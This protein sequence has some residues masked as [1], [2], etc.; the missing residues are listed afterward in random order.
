M[1]IKDIARLAGVSVSTV[2]KILNNKADSIAEDTKRKVLQIA[3]EYHYTPYSGVKNI[4]GSNRFLLSV[5]CDLQQVSPG[6]L[7][8]VEQEADACGYSILL[9]DIH[10]QQNAALQK[11][12][13]L[14]KD[15]TDGVLLCHWAADKE[16]RV[17]LQ[18][19]KVPAVLV[20]A[21]GGGGLPAF[22][23]NWR[24][25][26]LAALEYL[27][28]FG[29]RH[30]GLLI[31]DK[32]QH[33]N[34][35]SICSI[36]QFYTRRERKYDPKLTMTPSTLTNLLQTGITGIL[37]IEQEMAAAFYRYAYQ[38]HLAIPQDISVIALSEGAGQAFIPPLTHLRLDVAALAQA[39][40][41]ALVAQ[42]EGLAQEG[43][44]P[45]HL[46]PA[47]GIQEAE[48]VARP[49]NANGH[50]ASVVVVGSLNLDIVMN[51]PAMPTRGETLLIDSLSTLPGGKGANQ[52]VGAAKLGGDVSLVGC[53]GNDPGG[54]VVYNALRTAG[55]NTKGVTVDKDIETG[56]A[57]INVAPGGDSFIEVYPGANHR[58]TLRHIQRNAELFRLAKY[59]L[60]QTELHIKAVEWAL[61]CAWEN[62]TPVICKPCS[63]DA[64]GPDLLQKIYLLVPNQKEAARLAGP[65][66]SLEQQADY[67]IQNGCKE[68]IITLA[69][70]GCFYKKP[71]EQGRR[72]AAHTE[73][74]AGPADTTGASDAFISALAV[75]L[76]EGHSTETAIRFAN[77]AAGLSVLREGVQSSLPD[78]ITMEMRKHVYLGS[79]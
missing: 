71:G 62:Q 40:V 4:G 20:N 69:E 79:P 38:Q 3:R 65:D 18:N 22:S 21:P 16:A 35:E 33:R 43:D 15:K 41:S 25:A 68:V 76:A 14:L 37:C 6:F 77:L 63:I 44:S 51:V 54:K 30:I 28:N 39:G 55:V 5:L 19:Q 73:N 59:C 24:D 56:K 64:I 26:G 58:I 23:C 8:A 42:I 10:G 31:S 57:Y 66:L 48:S 67:F 1:T 34:R 78:R 47:G 61:N 7:Q 60:V 32:E 46:L 9:A 49:N 27:E 17:W 75:S 74:G 50:A 36:E 45:P 70:K 53:I 12:L 11:K 72:F 29:H 2:S 13:Q 52:A